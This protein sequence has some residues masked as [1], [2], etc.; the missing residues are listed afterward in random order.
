[1]M[2]PRVLVVGSD[3]QPELM[4]ELH[5]LRAHTRG[6]RP[7]VVLTNGSIRSADFEG[8]TWTRLGHALPGVTGQ[9]GFLVGGEL[10][11]KPADDPSRIQALRGDHDGV[12]DNGC[13]TPQPGTR[14]A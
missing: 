3:V 1:M 10:I 6:V 7:D 4:H 5:I 8:D 11:G 13:R 9:L 14:P 2:C 12:K